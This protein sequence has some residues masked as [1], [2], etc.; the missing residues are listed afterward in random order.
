MPYHPLFHVPRF[1]FA[2]RDRFFL[3]IEASDPR[4]DVL[5]TRRFLEGLGGHG[6][7]EVPY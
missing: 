6:I 5:E 2:S 7:S 1:E 3:C 4:F